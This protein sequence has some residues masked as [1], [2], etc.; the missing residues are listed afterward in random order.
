MTTTALLLL[1]AEAGRTAND[2]LLKAICCYSTGMMAHLQFVVA[3]PLYRKSQSPDC[4]VEAGF[5][6]GEN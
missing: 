2:L 3:L 6:H 5:V 4:S 1:L